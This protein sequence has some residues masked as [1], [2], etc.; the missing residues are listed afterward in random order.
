[1]VAGLM[2]AWANPAAAADKKAYCATDVKINLALNQLFL[3]STNGQPSA[4][5]IQQAQ[6]PILALLD[7]AVK[8]AP[9][10]IVDQVKIVANALHANFQTGLNDPALNDA[11]TKIDAYEVKSCGYH[12]INVTAIDYRFQGVPKTVKTGIVLINF[13]NAGSE[14]HEINI[15]RIKTTDTAKTLIALP[16]GQGR[17]RVELLG[18][19]SS[20]P[21]QSSVGYFQLTKPGRYVAVCLV[22]QGTTAN[23]PGTGPQH[24][25]LGMF[26]EFKV[27]K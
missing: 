10:G 7:Q 23:H 11:F 22:P 4:A 8:T 25:K 21:G 9:P 12:V 13:K 3:G 6:G 5:A 18:N 26:A 15:A 20:D 17:T 19:T 1:L 14:S 27:T 16:Q 2:L 24:A